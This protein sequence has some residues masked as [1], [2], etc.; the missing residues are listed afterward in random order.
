MLKA[1][2]K[3]RNTTR[4][5]VPPMGGKNE[6]DNL[7]LVR[8]RAG[9]EK[10]CPASCVDGS[11]HLPLRQGGFDASSNPLGGESH[12]LQ[13]ALRRV[14]IQVLVWHAQTQHARSTLHARQ[15]LGDR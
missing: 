11:P 15:V 4:E 10:P 1:G 6:K 12:T 8:Q 5:A 9:F 14:G 13:Q 3:T 7:N 2:S